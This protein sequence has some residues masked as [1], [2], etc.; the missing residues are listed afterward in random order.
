MLLTLEHHNYYPYNIKFKSICLLQNIEI[1][2]KKNYNNISIYN[3]LDIL[4]LSFN[5]KD[6]LISN[7]NNDSKTILIKKY[8]NDF[9]NDLKLNKNYLESIIKSNIN[10]DIEFSNKKKKKI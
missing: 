7:L 1:K 3:Y 2:K 9:Y 4:I 6:I 10:N 8:F 5:N